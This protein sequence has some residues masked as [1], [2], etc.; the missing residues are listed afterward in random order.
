M[1]AAPEP[2]SPTPDGDV[3]AIIG[4]ARAAALRGEPLTALSYWSAARTASPDRA[5][6]YLQEVRL[7]SQ[8]GQREAAEAVLATGVA[9][10]PGD[11]DLAIGFARAAQDRGDWAASAVRWAQ[12][13]VQ[14]PAR[15]EGITAV[16]QQAAH[17]RD[18]P[19]AAEAWQQARLR[20]PDSAVPLIHQAICLRQMQR[21]ADAELLLE[22][23]I[24]RFPANAD[25]V[26]EYARTAHDRQ[27]WS[28]A[29]RRWR[30]L[31][32]VTP[33]MALGYAEGSWAATR[34]GDQAEAEM[35]LTAAI[36]KF[37]DNADLHVRWANLASGTRRWDVAAERWQMVVERFPG[38]VS[39]YQSGSAALIQLGRF[40]AATD[41]LRQGMAHAPA[42][43]VFEFARDEAWVAMHQKDHAA[44]LQRFDAL[45][46][47]YPDRPAGYLGAGYA[48]VF[49]Q[50]F[51]EAEQV[52]TEG[53]AACADVQEMARRLIEAAIRLMAE[54]PD[55]A[56]R[57]KGYLAAFRQRFP[58]DP[59]GYWLDVRLHVRRG[60]YAEA[61]TLAREG[62]ARWPNDKAL[63]AEHATVLQRAGGDAPAGAGG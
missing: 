41:L 31:R 44:A 40:D 28:E 3:E 55:A 43:Q 29:V 47:R 48:L 17:E 26:R 10:C 8:L 33:D 6:L 14:F 23:G 54:E 16:A 45:R 27:D 58:D 21:H 37:P 62:L 5:D 63:R 7:L 38:T 53:I 42:T 4:E 56:D 30:M 1:T 13:R 59:S 51:S 61:D 9:H 19:R 12:V 20:L 50:R 39:A 15:A 49:L 25:V 22:D 57:A 24:A 34:A 52:L 11:A 18:W 2:E 32:D 46:E 35:I 60:A 36:A